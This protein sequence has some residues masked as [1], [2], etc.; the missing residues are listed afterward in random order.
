MNF[1]KLV[2]RVL[3]ESIL[4][5]PALDGEPEVY[6]MKC[7]NTYDD[8]ASRFT[9]STLQYWRFLQGLIRTRNSKDASIVRSFATRQDF[10]EYTHFVKNNLKQIINDGLKS[11]SD[12]AK[13]ASTLWQSHLNILNDDIDIFLQSIP[14]NAL[15]TYY[16]YDDNDVQGTGDN[17]HLV[18]EVDVNAY[19]KQMHTNNPLNNL[20]DF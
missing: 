20:I 9:G 6:G 19:I 10:I 8:K 13:Y 17:L 15:G 2:E 4:K 16:F 5:I 1:V 7:R 18:F 12:R 11:H 14:E 3:R